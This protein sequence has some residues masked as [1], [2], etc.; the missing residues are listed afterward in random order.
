MMNVPKN[1]KKVITFHRG[2]KAP[3]KKVAI[4]QRYGAWEIRNSTHHRK[5][6]DQQPSVFVEL[7]TITNDLPP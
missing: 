1:D 3:M 6:E 5:T 2:V 7:F 4:L